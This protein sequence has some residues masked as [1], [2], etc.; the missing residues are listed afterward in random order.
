MAAGEG[1]DAWATQLKGVPAL[2]NY[3]LPE[4]TLTTDL[5]KKSYAT[6]VDLINHPH[7]DRNNLGAFSDAV[8]E[9]VLQVLTGDMSAEK[10]AQKGQEELDK[11]NF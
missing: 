4:G 2:N 10:A 3:S 1:V 5:Q 9:N 6:M 11:G 8:G 7:S